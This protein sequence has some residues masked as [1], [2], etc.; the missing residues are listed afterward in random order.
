VRSNNIAADQMNVVECGSAVD[1]ALLQDG[2]DTC[3]FDGHVAR[4]TSV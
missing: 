1:G 2:H 4:R 3:F